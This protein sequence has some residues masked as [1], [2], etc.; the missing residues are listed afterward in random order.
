[1]PGTD[2]ERES[3]LRATWIVLGRSGF[4]GFKVQLVL[5]EAGVSARTFYRLYADK[6][7]LFLALLHEEMSRAAPRIR[8]AVERA[9]GPVD[10]VAAWVRSVI[11]GASDPRRAARTRLFGSLQTVQRRFPR[12]VAPG[13]EGLRQPL[14]DAIIDGKDDGT[15]PWADPERD[16]VLVYELVGG[17][18]SDLALAIPPTQPLETVIRD[19]TDFTLRALGVP[20]DKTAG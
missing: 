20:P 18:L 10:R 9:D 19:A 1:V 17:L 8:T 15:F 2:E 6:D 11:G 14:L 3:I 12:E 16:A 7:E 5:R 13:M 4:E